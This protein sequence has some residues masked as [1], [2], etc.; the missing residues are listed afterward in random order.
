[1]AATGAPEAV[2]KSALLLV[3]TVLPGTET[4]A[5]VSCSGDWLRDA[6]L[7]VGGST[8]NGGTHGSDDAVAGAV[9]VASAGLR[10]S[11]CGARL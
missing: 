4:D 5:E 9:R 10:I 7:S 11:L 2:G 1:M 8:G 6:V 3:C